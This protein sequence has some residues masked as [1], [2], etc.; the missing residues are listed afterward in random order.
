MYRA[1]A[2]RKEWKD[3]PLAEV[4]LKVRVI[5]LLMAE[6]EK[7]GK[8]ARCPGKALVRVVAHTKM[9]AGGQRVVGPLPRGLHF[10]GKILI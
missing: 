3:I 4:L 7:K 1:Q 6:V 9:K 5:S 8:S 10:S 2:R